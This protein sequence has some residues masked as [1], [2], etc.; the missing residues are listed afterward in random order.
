MPDVPSFGQERIRPLLRQRYPMLLLDR[1]LGLDDT[2]APTEIVAVKAVTVSEPCYAQLGEGA[3]TAGFAY[4]LALQLESFGQAVSVLWSLGREVGDGTV[5]L[6]AGLREVSVTA[7][8][9]PG[10]VMEHS[11]H[12]VHASGASWTYAG[13]TRVAGREVL[14]VGSLLVVARPDAVLLGA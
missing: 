5:P 8:V 11:A 1:V 4:P 7:P 3:G 10:D 12:L 9:L 13:S 14:S 2:E 6:L